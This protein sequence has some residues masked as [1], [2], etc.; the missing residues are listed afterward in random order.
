MVRTFK[1]QH[2]V[3]DHYIVFLVAADKLSA[4]WSIADL[5]HHAASHPLPEFGLRRPVFLAVV[6]HDQSVLFLLP[7]L[8]LF[9]FLVV[10]L[11]GH[12]F[13]TQVTPTICSNQSYKPRREA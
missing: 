12:I 3:A 4:Q 5:S 10:F 8:E 6:T 7:S 9:Q 11:G 13:Y 1:I 2:G